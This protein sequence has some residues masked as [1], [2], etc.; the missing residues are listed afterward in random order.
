MLGWFKNNA[1]KGIDN[2]NIRSLKVHRMHEHLHLKSIMQNSSP[3]DVSK[4]LDRGQEIISN[5]LKFQ[6]LFTKRVEI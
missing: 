4:S 3:V 2:L 5:E 1:H 6:K